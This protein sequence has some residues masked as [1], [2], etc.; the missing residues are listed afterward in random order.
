MW[1]STRKN[2]HEFESLNARI[3][4]LQASVANLEEQGEESRAREVTLQASIAQLCKE[5]AELKT[6][7]VGL[8][9]GVKNE[10]DEVKNEFGEMRKLF[11]KCIQTIQTSGNVS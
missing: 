1:F 2:N 5:N 7:Q 4:T 6:H 11:H 10:F 3:A 8:S 9:N